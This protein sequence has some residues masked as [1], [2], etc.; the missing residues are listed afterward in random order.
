[1][2]NAK[3]QQSMTRDDVIKIMEKEL[4]ALSE[5]NSVVDVPEDK[6]RTSEVMLEIAKFLLD[7]QR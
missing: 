2:E 5:Y 7:T 3:Q 1:M 6:C 4:Q